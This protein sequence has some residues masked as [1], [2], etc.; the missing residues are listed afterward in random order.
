MREMTAMLMVVIEVED[1]LSDDELQDQGRQALIER[2]SDRHTEVTL[3]R[4]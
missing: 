3:E 2:L 4:L 1:D